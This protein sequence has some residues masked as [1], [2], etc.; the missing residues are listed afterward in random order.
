MNAIIGNAFRMACAAQL[1]KASAE[2]LSQQIENRNNQN[3]LQEKH[4]YNNI[5]KIYWVSNIKQ[6]SFIL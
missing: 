6:S 1:Q 5:D 2:V 4:N 3:N